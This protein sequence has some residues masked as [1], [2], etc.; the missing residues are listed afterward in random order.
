MKLRPGDQPLPISVDTRC[1][2]DAVI[3]DLRK[4]PGDLGLDIANAVISDLEKRKVLGMERYGSVLRPF[5]GR[6]CKLDAYQECLDLLNYAMQCR[7]ELGFNDVWDGLYRLARF[8]ALCIKT[9][10]VLDD[11]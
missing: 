11:A 6:D 1:V 7:M 10:M 5:N 3:D 8:A 9:S 4:Y 2:Q